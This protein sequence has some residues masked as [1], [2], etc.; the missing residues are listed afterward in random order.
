[1]KKDYFKK[2]CYLFWVFMLGSF[3]GFVLENLL[4]LFRGNYELRQGL[5]YEPLIPIYGFGLVGFY[6]IYNNLKF[7]NENKYYKIFII[8]IIAFLT[9]GIVE[10]IGSYIQ[11]AWFGTISWDY[12]YM[13]FDLNGRTSLHHSCIW[14]ILGVV[15]YYLILPIINKMF[16]FK[17]NK[18]GMVFTV[19]MS[20]VLLFDSSISLL[21]CN[22]RTERRDKIQATS[23]LDIYLD[24]KYPDE[25][26]DRI[27]NNA[28][29]VKK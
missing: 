22:R 18:L 13:K 3:L 6:L 7:K 19:I 23:S 5:I 4:M 27:F 12:S 11:E 14:G 16:T 24:N 20:F 10:Y 26:V 15:F 21:A 8:F 17:I 28:N 29:I 9:G 1:M 25:Y 2:Y